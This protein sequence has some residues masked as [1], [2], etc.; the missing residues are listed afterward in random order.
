MDWGLDGLEGGGA[1][2]ELHEQWAE[3]K[4]AEKKVGRRGRVQDLQLHLQKEATVHGTK[5]ETH[6]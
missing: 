3:K 1:W 5:F 2:M 4:W 6:I